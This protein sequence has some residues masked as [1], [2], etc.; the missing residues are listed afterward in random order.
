MLGLCLLADIQFADMEN[1]AGHHSSN[2]RLS[3]FG[4]S[5][6]SSLERKSSKEDASAVKVKPQ[7]EQLS[8]GNT[9]ALSTSQ[10]SV[11]SNDSKYVC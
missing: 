4:H 8:I 2:E 1:V 5:S 6:S 11:A 9:S 10:H 7:T 3:S